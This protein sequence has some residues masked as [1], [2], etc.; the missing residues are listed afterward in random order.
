M[1]RW[2]SIL[3]PSALVLVLIGFAA[4]LVRNASRQTPAGQIREAAKDPEVR[5]K[6]AIWKPSPAQQALL[7]EAERTPPDPLSEELVP[8]LAAVAPDYRPLV[9]YDT[10]DPRHIHH[11]ARAWALR[12]GSVTGDPREI[13][14]FLEILREPLD[15]SPDQ[16]ELPRKGDLRPT[17]LIALYNV[18]IAGDPH[19][20]R[21]PTFEDIAI[22]HATSPSYRIHALML[23]YLLDDQNGLSETGRGVL[24]EW[25][26]KPGYRDRVPRFAENAKADFHRKDD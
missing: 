9:F 7:D 22:E 12:E 25:L 26:S 5:A 19:R 1:N 21:F 6:R 4:L 13:E 8:V 16:P 18:V 14:P 3:I 23:L 17:S 11:T 15:T 20:A 24:N 2:R 10:S